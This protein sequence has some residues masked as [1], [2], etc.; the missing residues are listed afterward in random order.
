MQVEIDLDLNAYANARAHFESRKAKA[1]KQQKTV[2]QNAKALLAAEKTAQQK[3]TQ[4]S[5]PLLFGIYYKFRHAHDSSKLPHQCSG[6]IF[7]IITVFWVSTFR[8]IM[9]TCK[10]SKPERYMRLSD[11]IYVS[12][13]ILVQV[14]AAKVVQQ[15]R[16][17][18]WFEKFNWYRLSSALQLII[19]IPS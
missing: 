3:L 13:C 14:K 7:L 15:L 1:A 2:E 5:C 9:L 11:Q 4:V 8:L 6:P 16:K 17:P 18:Y 12:S 10:A 19:K